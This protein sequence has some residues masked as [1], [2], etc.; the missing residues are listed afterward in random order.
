MFFDDFKLY[1]AAF[2]GGVLIG[3]LIYREVQKRYF[4]ERSIPL[5]IVIDQSVIKGNVSSLFR[6]RERLSI[7]LNQIEEEIDS[8]FSQLDKIADIETGERKE[9]YSVS[10]LDEIVEIDGGSLEEVYEAILSGGEEP[11][12]YILEEE[13]SENNELEEDELISSTKEPSSRTE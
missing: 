10:D 4:R 13:E 7:V 5:S 9:I 6:L 12:N 2:V 3:A 8:I 11:E 1:I